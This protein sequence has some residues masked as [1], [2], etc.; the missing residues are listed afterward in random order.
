MNQVTELAYGKINLYLDVLGRR[1]DGYHN[2]KSVMQ[3]V[4]LYD[5]VTI[6]E[7]EEVSMTCSDPTLTCGEDNLCLKAARAFL[8][9][10]E[11]VAVISIWKKRFPAKRGWEEAVPTVPP[12]CGD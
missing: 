4:S 5:A 1:E 9:P 6:T 8:P 11:A 3:T 7:A 2:I 12:F 10:M